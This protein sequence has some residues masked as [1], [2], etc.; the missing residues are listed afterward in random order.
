MKLMFCPAF[1]SDS[2]LTGLAVPIPTLSVD[3]VSLTTSP[4]SVNP[5][6]EA[7]TVLRHAPPCMQMS[8]VAL[9]VPTTCKVE[10]GAVVPIP[11]FPPSGFS[12]KSF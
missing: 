9:I 2:A 1:P 12:S 4:S 3:V 10:L 11:M 6:P 8:V 5:P 7:D